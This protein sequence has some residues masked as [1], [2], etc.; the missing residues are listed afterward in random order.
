MKRRLKGPRLTADHRTPNG[1]RWAISGATTTHEGTK[2]TA[3]SR[4]TP[5]LPS[6]Q[7]EAGSCSSGNFRHLT[8]DS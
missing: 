3:P 8:S 4:Q 1:G 2:G 5:A 6:L 7:S